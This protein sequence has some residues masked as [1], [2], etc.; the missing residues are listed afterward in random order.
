MLDSW[1]VLLRKAL[2]RY[3]V[4]DREYVV[5][6]GPGRFLVVNPSGVKRNGVVCKHIIMHYN[7]ILYKQRGQALGLSIRINE[8]YVGMIMFGYFTYF[9]H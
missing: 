2:T 1:R 4:R 6:I 9:L 7:S 5:L 8:L 3:R